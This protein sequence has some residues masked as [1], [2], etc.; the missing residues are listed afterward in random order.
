MTDKQRLINRQALVL[1]NFW[2]MKHK[3]DK[4]VG[5]LTIGDFI[6]LCEVFLNE[7]EIKNDRN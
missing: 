2:S 5:E 3:N 4:R 1:F 7:L 6:E